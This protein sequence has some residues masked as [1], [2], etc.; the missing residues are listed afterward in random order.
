MYLTCY[1]FFKVMCLKV[2]SSYNFCTENNCLSQY[3]SLFNDFYNKLIFFFFHSAAT[4]QG[5][6]TGHD[7]AG[8]SSTVP[9][10]EKLPPQMQVTLKMAEHTSIS[11]MMTANYLILTWAIFLS[12]GSHL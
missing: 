9:S 6:V 5:E 11:H 10:T 1:D 12:L 7:V 3:V 2:S 8:G 4:I